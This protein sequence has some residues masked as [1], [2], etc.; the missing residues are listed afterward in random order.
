MVSRLERLLIDWLESH[1]T[2]WGKVFAYFLVS[3]VL[4]STLFVILETTS[5]NDKYGNIFRFFDAF[6]FF[7]FAIEYTFRILIAPKRLKFVF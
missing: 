4:G 2:K 3:L 6:V 1:E 5:L 7:V